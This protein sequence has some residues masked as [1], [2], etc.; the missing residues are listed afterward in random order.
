MQLNVSHN[1]SSHTRSK[2]VNEA[3]NENHD[4][5]FIFHISTFESLIYDCDNKTKKKQ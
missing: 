1:R 2:F 5:S 3:K 4:Y